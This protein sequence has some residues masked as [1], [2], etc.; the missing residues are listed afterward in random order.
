M[1]YKNGL[2]AFNLEMTDKV[3]R[4][5]YS[6]DT[7]WELVKK[8][9]GIDV[10]PSSTPEIQ[11]AASEAFRK[12][13]DYG[14]AW[15]TLTYNQIFNGKYTK[16][17]HASYATGG[18]DYSNDVVELFDDPDDA[19]KLDLFEFY[20]QRDIAT[21]TK[22]YNVHYNQGKS[23][24]YVN[25]TGIYTT[26]MSGLLEILGWDMLLVSA[27][28]DTKAFGELTNRYAEWIGQYFKALSLSD[29][30]IVMVHDD[31]TWTS[32]AFLH[33]DFYRTFI[34]PNYKKM[35]APLIE[36]GKKII[37]TS[38]GNYTEFIDDIAACG[39]NSFVMEPGT[40]MQYIADK[41]G[42]TH[43]FT[44]NF[45]TRILLTGTKED[46]ETEIKRCMNIGKKYAGFF[47]AVGNHIPSNT[48]IDN[49]LYYNDLYE[50]YSKR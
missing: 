47:L 34:F 16:M 22:E 46:I 20:G 28:T 23:A 26:L 36:K 4:C 49:A 7:H 27:G 43:S 12:K 9:T 5:E 17:G 35:F 48:P 50:K 24:N 45:D 41:Y 21:L 10:G 13:W 2:A 42:K 40:D 38:D 8:V 3:P 1:S 39:V 19:L 6:A 18:T 33:P 31:I 25:M 37:Y 29:C 11:G 32:G 44:G 14:Y 15:N 30:P